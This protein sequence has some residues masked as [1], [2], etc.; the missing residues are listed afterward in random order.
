MKNNNNEASKLSKR[1]TSA[2]RSEQSRSPGTPGH[3][4]KRRHMTMT[5]T[6]TEPPRATRRKSKAKAEPAPE[7]TTL[8]VVIPP[9]V[10]RLWRYNKKG[11]VYRSAAYEDWIAEAGWELHAQ[12]PKPVSSPVRIVLRAGLPE[13]PRDLDNIGKA[14]IDFAADARPHPERRGRCPPH[15]AM[16]SSRIARPACGRAVEDGRAVTAPAALAQARLEQA[17]ADRTA[18][19]EALAAAMRALEPTFSAPVAEAIWWRAWESK[20]KDQRYTGTALAMA[21]ASYRRAQRVESKARL[22]AYRIAPPA[23]P[24]TA[25]SGLS[26]DEVYAALMERRAA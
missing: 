19:D 3:S 12:R 5:T 21:Y 7:S 8:S 14:A 9:S 13:R 2:I 4:S 11:Q 26:A 10:N 18:A 17:I 25:S 23:S 22:A 16:G 24:K 15:D 20:F 1:S 6:S